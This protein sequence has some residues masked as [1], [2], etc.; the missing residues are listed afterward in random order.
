MLRVTKKEAIFFDFFTEGVEMGLKAAV[1]L[2]E[3]MANYTDIDKKIAAIENI[4]HECDIHAHKIMKHL[5]AAFITPI[6]R[7][8]IYLITK[9]IDNI[10][11]NIEEIAHRFSMFN[12]KEIRPEAI[13][14]G[15]LITESIKQLT[16]LMKELVHLKFSDTLKQKIIEVNRLENVGDVI[17]RKALKNLFADETDAIEVIKWKGI[18]TYLEKAIDACEEVANIV[19]GVVMKHA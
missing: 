13:E 8:D 1:A 14:L 5:N 10:V 7:E 6:D 17:F 3:L 12:V 11:D 15:K 18:Y 19:E 16:E 4:E 9:E 2:E